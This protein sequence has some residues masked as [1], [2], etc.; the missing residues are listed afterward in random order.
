MPKAVLSHWFRSTLMPGWTKL[1]FRSST[2]ALM[3][4]VLVSEMVTRVV[5]AC[6]SIPGVT[7]RPMTL[8]SM[9]ATA[10]QLARFFSA[11]SRVFRAS[12]RLCSMEKISFSL[13]WPSMRTSTWPPLTLR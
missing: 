4:T 11:C 5:L 10:L 3:M 6:S 8:P 13:S 2:W 1:M 12:S 9:G 7:E